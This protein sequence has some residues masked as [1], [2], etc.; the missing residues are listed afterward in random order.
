MI[1]LCP[2]CGRESTRAIDVSSMLCEH[3][4]QPSEFDPRTTTMHEHSNASNSTHDETSLEDAL[5]H[6]ARTFQPPIE[7]MYASDEQD[8]LSS[9]NTSMQPNI[10]GISTHAEP[11]YASQSTEVASIMD[12]NEQSKQSTEGTVRMR[13]PLISQDGEAQDTSS[14]PTPSI[15]ETLQTYDEFS[16]EQLDIRVGEEPEDDAHTMGSA[17]VTDYEDDFYPQLHVEDEN[18]LEH[19]LAA[20][21][22]HSDEDSRP[23]ESTAISANPLL[24]SAHGVVPLVETSFPSSNDPLA[25]EESTAISANP[26]LQQPI[27]QAAQWDGHAYSAA[28]ESAQNVYVQN[29]LYT[30][31]AQH[32][33]TQAPVA[34][35]PIV[36]NVQ[37]EL[38]VSESMGLNNTPDMS[39]ETFTTMETSDDVLLEPSKD[40]RAWV[41]VLLLFF[42][43]FGPISMLLGIL[44]NR[45]AVEEGDFQGKGLAYT[46][47]FLGGLQTCIMVTLV[48]LFVFF[49]QNHPVLQSVRQ[50]IQ[51]VLGS[52]T[53]LDYAKLPPE[54][55]ELTDEHALN[56]LRKRGWVEPKTSPRSMYV[57]QVPQTRH[58]YIHW[59]SSKKQ[60]NLRTLLLYSQRKHWR[61]ASEDTGKAYEVR[62]SQAGK[63]QLS[64]KVARSLIRTFWKVRGKFTGT[65]ITHLYVVQ[66]KKQ[67]YAYAYW[68]LTKQVRDAAIQ[69]WKIKSLYHRSAKGKWY[70]SRYAM[71]LPKDEVFAHSAQGE[72]VLSKPLAI[73]LIQ[74]YHKDNQKPFSPH[75]ALYIHQEKSALTARAFWQSGRKQYSSLFR[76]SHQG[77]WFLAR[78]AEPSVH[79][80]FTYKIENATSC[81]PDSTRKVLLRY[82]RNHG[83]TLL[84]GHF[85]S[86]GHKGKPP[87]RL[88]KIQ[89]MALYSKGSQSTIRVRWQAQFFKKM[90]FYES[91]FQ[92]SQQGVWYLAQ[93]FSSKQYDLRFH[94]KGGTQLQKT[95]AQELIQKMWQEDEQSEKFTGARIEDLYAFQGQ[96]SSLAWAHWRKRQ[97]GLTTRMRTELYRAHNGKWYIG[98]Y[99]MGLGYS[100]RFSQKG[101]KRLPTQLAVQL[102]Q[103][104]LRAK[105]KTKRKVLTQKPEKILLPYVY[106]EMGASVAYLRWVSAKKGKHTEVNSLF[107]HSNDGKWYLSIA[108]TPQLTPTELQ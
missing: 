104:Y 101:P 10:P 60:Q 103:R 106:Q 107:H 42:V 47:I 16:Q 97:S 56:I 5:E 100:L 28:P 44:Y 75:T 12:E 61:I 33:H 89:M 1:V 66:D 94:R 50:T 21:S 69:Q 20:A 8:A 41:G 15:P 68:K 84:L 9:S 7:S 91:I 35:A 30:Q 13:S 22:L 2:S 63:S 34:P 14:I 38:N 76:Y 72:R 82:L 46:A 73:K 85:A 31:P 83:R 92:R 18:D 52:S 80:S 6:P 71:R 40:R 45:R 78:P 90:A 54:S 65:R 67:R 58:A 27:E 53:H 32:A 108:S 25:Q 81:T 102:V 37:P 17:Q 23:T 36:P 88:P 86:Y 29:E 79:P 57:Y 87:R 48:G 99:D 74:E 19:T 62:A 59:R 93:P 3:C 98:R 96:S 55:Q 4:H 77:K 39:P 43:L 70:L 95:L 51:H 11:S 24:S 105:L 64:E 26:L 49:P